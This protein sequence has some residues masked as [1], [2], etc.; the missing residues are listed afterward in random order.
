MTIKEYTRKVGYENEN[1]SQGYLNIQECDD[2]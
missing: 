1:V 2:I